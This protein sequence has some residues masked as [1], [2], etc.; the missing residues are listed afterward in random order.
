ME[1]RKE[2]CMEGQ[3]QSYLYSLDQCK[4]WQEAESKSKP[5]QGRGAFSPWDSSMEEREKTHILHGH[6][7]ATVVW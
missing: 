1:R 6:V 2:K 7:F 4:G 5:V 3:E